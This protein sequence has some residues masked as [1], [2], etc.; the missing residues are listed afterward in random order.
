MKKNKGM[1]RWVFMLS[2]LG[3][4][5][6]SVSVQAVNLPRERLKDITILPDPK[7]MELKESGTV[8]VESDGT[9]KAMIVIGNTMPMERDILAAEELNARLNDLGA[10]PLP[11]KLD[12]EVSD[13]DI[14]D[15]NL[16][17]IGNQE[18]NK[19]SKKYWTSGRRKI[20]AAMPPAQGYVIRTVQGKGK[21]SR[22]KIFLAGTDSMGS[23]YAAV[24][25]RRLIIAYEGRIVAVKAYVRDWPDFPYRAVTGALDESKPENVD[26]VFRRKMNYF[27]FK[28]NPIL[29]VY[30]Y[31]GAD[32]PRRAKQFYE[33]RRR[34]FTIAAFIFGVN[35]T[36]LTAP[37][38]EPDKSIDQL[39][40]E[41]DGIK[42]FK[43]KWLLNYSRDDLIRKYARMTAESM[44]LLNQNALIIHEVMDTYFHKRS[45]K[46]RERFGNNRAAAMTNYFRIFYEE[47]RK[48]LPEADLVY[49]TLPYSASTVDDKESVAI[50]RYY[51]EN[52]PFDEH[53]YVTVREG[54][55]D[56]IEAWR[57]IWGWDKKMWYFDE[58]AW[59]WAAPMYSPRPSMNKTFDFGKQ[60]VIS[61]SID[62][63]AQPMP[64][65]TMVAAEFGWN[66]QAPGSRY[67]PDLRDFNNNSIAEQNYRTLFPPEM[68]EEDLYHL[69]RASREVWG[70]RVGGIMMGMFDKGLN[71][72]F[73][74]DPAQ[75]RKRISNGARGTPVGELTDYDYD[76]MMFKQ[77]D[78]A[79]RAAAAVDEALKEK[80]A[81]KPYGRQFFSLYYAQAHLSRIFTEGNVLMIEAKRLIGADKDAEARKKLDEAVSVLRQGRKRM[82]RVVS[83]DLKGWPAKFKDWREIGV[84]LEAPVYSAS[85]KSNAGGQL[86]AL[87]NKIKQTWE[88]R[89]AVRTKFK[90]VQQSRRGEASRF[91]AQRTLRA[92]AVRR[93]PK[94]DGNLNEA[95]WK[96]AEWVTRFSLND[97]PQAA[98][99]QTRAAI[100]YDD[101]NIYVG[102]QCESPYTDTSLDTARERD[103]WSEKEN[104]VEVFFQPD[105]SRDDYFQFFVNTLGPRGELYYM[106]KND[107]SSSQRG[108]DPAWQAKVVRRA[109]EW[110]AELAIPIAALT[111]TRLGDKARPRPGRRWRVNITRSTPGVLGNEYSALRSYGFHDVDNFSELMFE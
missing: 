63:L 54:S 14:Q 18:Q 20:T 15:Y 10:K 30:G 21:D 27:A 44:K 49:I 82:E 57:D 93:A 80:E 100:L 17:L 111:A 77:R 38:L 37:I 23:V 74:A 103:K 108:W 83:S 9:P 87:E 64:L 73:I 2:L 81:M 68:T 1:S 8:L 102:L 91:R 79:R 86:A 101:K 88:Q 71:I 98:V 92:K 106:K 110:T 69:K 104:Y 35:Y 3:Y 109:K 46:S 61:I 53:T 5:G 65:L 99:Q 33:M 60:D 24:T 43:F 6:I 7:Q 40:E 12:A 28:G 59:G 96:S 76:E 58:L 84:S 62:H 89:E 19:L 67:W 55:R 13:E 41:W 78:A 72:N 70:D 16:I 39:V 26:F 95:G 52:L 51:A 31:Y 11:V 34:G 48:V 97:R 32:Y 29:S 107:I 105:E 4:L 75:W 56:S 94:I 22:D 47:L 25:M 45:Q 66:S 90:A 85:K 36:P 42:I 50:L